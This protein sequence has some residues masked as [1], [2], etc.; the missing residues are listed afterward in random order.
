MTVRSVSYIGSGNIKKNNLSRLNLIFLY[1]QKELN[2]IN[3]GFMIEFFFAE[4]QG[5]HVKDFLLVRCPLNWLGFQ[6]FLCKSSLN[7]QTA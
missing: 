6:L 7:A 5:Q 3:D 4:L 2:Y 1:F